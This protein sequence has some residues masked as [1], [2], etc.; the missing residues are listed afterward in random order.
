MQIMA[1]QSEYGQV[2][3]FQEH[4]EH[5]KRGD[6]VGVQGVAGRSRLGELSIVPQAVYLL[7]PCLHTLSQEGTVPEDHRPQQQS[8]FQDHDIRYRQR[9][10]DMLVH[11]DVVS[12][13]HK[14]AKMMQSLRKFFSMRNFVEVETP[15]L[16][17]QAGGAS[18][19]PFRTQ[20]SQY[21]G[22]GDHGLSLR[23]APE[24]YLKQC[25]IGG[26]ERVFELG[27]QFR[28][29]G[30]DATHNPEFTTLEFYWAHTNMEQLQHTTRELLQM[31]ALEVTGSLQLKLHPQWLSG[32]FGAEATVDL[33]HFNRI[34]FCD[35]IEEKL[36][37]KLPHP[38]DED[39]QPK[40]L[41]LCKG[42]GLVPSTNSEDSKYSTASELYDLLFST[43]VEPDLLQPT[44][45]CDHPV[46]MSPLA[47]P[48]TEPGKEGLSNRF[49]LFVAGK[50]LCNAYLELNSPEE[51][52][53]RFQQQAE[54][55]GRGAQETQPPDEAFC[56]A[57]EY[58]LPPTAGFG[59]GVDRFCMLLTQQRHIRDVI[60][61]PF[62]RRPSSPSPSPSPQG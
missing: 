2:E 18:A 57:L 25:V 47:Q 9:Y 56:T 28:N 17:M 22:E 54:D 30:L 26:L 50:E 55:Q 7:A 1:S 39:L 3:Q 20:K 61:F 6:V 41:A 29:E 46:C 42:Q 36:G 11:P 43:L 19:R 53:A 48:C 16:S 23:I 14:R 58:G 4:M 27:K 15:I 38:L 12:V 35:S 21:L 31:V 34:R 60:L 45:V 33:S 24:L 40:L 62:M 13:F 51:Q 32:V 59:L 49:E 37:V 52:R 44:F 8:T 5:V 10:L